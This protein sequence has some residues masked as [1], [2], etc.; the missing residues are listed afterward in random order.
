V[1]PRRPEPAKRGAPEPVALS[2][3]DRAFA[4]YRLKR[5]AEEEARTRQREAQ[6]RTTLYAEQ[7]RR[8][9]RWAVDAAEQRLVREDNVRDEIVRSVLDL[10]E[11]MEREAAGREG[12]GR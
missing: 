2:S 3:Q 10:A 7:L 9:E 4:A 6:E 11:R 8:A 5:E 12:K 1:V